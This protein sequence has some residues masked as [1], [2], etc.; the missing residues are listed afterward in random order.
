MKKCLLL[1]CQIFGL[2][3]NTLAN[4]EKY[5][6]LNKY[7]LTIPIEIQLSEKEKTFCQFFS[8]FLKSR[9][10]FKLFEQKDDRHKFCILEVMDPKNVVR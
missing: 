2:V 6:V 10:N 5:P 3:A 9:L 8:A 1:T 7:N 4:D